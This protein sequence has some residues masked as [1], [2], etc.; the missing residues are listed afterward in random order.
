MK[1][2]HVRSRRGDSPQR[3]LLVR[4][5][6]R[7]ARLGS[8]N[9]SAAGRVLKGDWKGVHIH[10]WSSTCDKGL[11]A[12][13]WVMSRKGGNSGQR[14]TRM[15]SLQREHSW[16]CVQVQ[17]HP[18]VPGPL[19]AQQSDG[20]EWISLL[21]DAL[22]LTSASTSATVMVRAELSKKSRQCACQW[23]CH[24]QKRLQSE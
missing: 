22:L 18:F 12:H 14:Q 24:S 5:C 20:L 23:Q 13:E 4:L 21:Y 7:A 17:L 1:Y 6:R 11:T 16:I 8:H 19:L 2:P 9:R 10:G 15:S 3:L